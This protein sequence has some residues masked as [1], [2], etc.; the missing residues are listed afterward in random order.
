MPAWRDSGLHGHVPDRCKSTPTL[1]SD[2]KGPLLQSAALTS[3][4][5]CPSVE[6]VGLLLCLDRPYCRGRVFTLLT[7]PLLPVQAECRIAQFDY[8]SCGDWKR[9]GSCDTWFSCPM[10]GC[11]GGD[12]R[13]SCNED[14]DEA[15][16]LNAGMA[17]DAKIAFFDIADQV[18]W[19][20]RPRFR[21]IPQAQRLVGPARI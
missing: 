3:Q 17:R 10:H 15:L 9:D 14:P 21:G 7:F 16:R 18:R 19:C 4:V 5:M 11:D 13:L 1:V 2:H 6:L 20:G 12:C 8:H